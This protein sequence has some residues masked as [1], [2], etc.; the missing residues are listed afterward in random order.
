MVPDSME[1]KNHK[2]YKI[3]VMDDEDYIREML[4][5][6]LEIIGHSV[7]IAENGNMAIY[8]YEE[9][10]KKGE[11]FDIVIL[12]LT[13]QGGKGGKETMSRLMEIDPD[14]CAI[15]AS[16]YSE[17]PIIT[18]YTEY[19]FKGRLAKPYLM[20]DLKNEILKIMEN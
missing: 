9:A 10:I 20:D 8:K 15:V 18:N 6:I 16:G 12:D 3:L 2:G 5:E 17:D 19:G 13:I 11:K 1:K 7:D 14:V 4:K